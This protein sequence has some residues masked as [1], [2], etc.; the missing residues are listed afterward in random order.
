[1]PPK[2][3][4]AGDSEST[5]TAIKRL[6]TGR[7]KCE[8]CAEA[9]DGDELVEKTKTECPDVAILDI[10]MPKMDGLK[11]VGELLRCSPNTA[12]LA[13]NFWDVPVLTAELKKVG[14]KGFVPNARMSTDLIRAIEII[15]DGGDFFGTEF[16]Q[17]A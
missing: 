5:R 7:T 4:L 2:I 9:A 17:T 6:I 10:S 3:L 13:Y 15:L 14:I 11:A 12:V 16:A 8:I 1:M